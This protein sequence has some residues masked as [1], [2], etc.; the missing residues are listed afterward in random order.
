ME[1]KVYAKFKKC[2]LWLSQVAF[3]GHIVKKDG[4]KVD[5]IKIEVV[6]DWPKS[7]TASELGFQYQPPSS[8]SSSNNNGDSDPETSDLSHGA[9]EKEKKEEV[10]GASIHQELAR[11]ELKENEE[12][13]IL[14]L[15]LGQIMEEQLGLLKVV[16]VQGRKLVI[17]D[18]KSTDPYVVVKLG[19]QTAKTK[20]INSCLNPVWNEELTFSLKEPNGVLN[21]PF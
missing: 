19:N 17:W 5:S 9:A 15:D 2:E 10:S 6:R 13:P 7:K 20:V 21:F 1:H 14:K 3:L 12:E 8:S 18:F 11:L 4:I 16:V